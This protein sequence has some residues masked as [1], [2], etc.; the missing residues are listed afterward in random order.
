M[1]DE[2]PLLSIV[3]VPLKPTPKRPARSSEKPAAAV[4]LNEPLLS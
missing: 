1:F 4:K 2:N 3:T